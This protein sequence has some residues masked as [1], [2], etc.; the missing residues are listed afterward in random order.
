MSS[1]AASGSRSAIRALVCTCV[2]LVAAPSVRAQTAPVERSFQASKAVVES[3]LRG[4]GAY[5]GGRLPILEGFAV[6]KEGSLDRYQRGYYQYSVQL[7]AAASGDTQ[8]R[9]TAKITAWYA[10]SDPSHSGY[11]VLPSNGRLEADLLD[12]LQQELP[13]QPQCSPA[14]FPRCR[15]S[16]LRHSHAV[17]PSRALPV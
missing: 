6:S 8:V 14:C 9:V 12:R 1:A 10:A 17:P 2:V 4:L 11:R 15:T 13:G 5:A 16:R 3:K 7:N